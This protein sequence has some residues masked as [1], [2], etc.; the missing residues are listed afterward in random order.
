VKS[1]K[2]NNREIQFKDVVDVSL[3]EN[4]DSD[5]EINTL[6]VIQEWFSGKDRFTFQTSGSTGQPKSIEFSRD[7]IVASAKRTNS[8]F[9]LQAGQTILCCLNT[10]F[11][12]GF[13]MLIRAFVGKLKLLVVEPTSN[14]LSLV[15]EE[16]IDFVAMT[17][18]QVLGAMEQIP[19]KLGH[20]KTL[21]VGGADVQPELEERLT[22]LKCQ[23][24]HSYAMTETLTHV[25][26][27]NMSQN[28]KI[29][30]ALEGVAF[31]QAE[32]TCLVVHDKVLKI[33]ELKT[34]DL[35]DLINDQKFQWLG[36]LDN[37]VNSGGIKIQI[38]KLELTIRDLLLTLGCASKICLV[39]IHDARLTNKLVLLI[40]GEGIDFDH[41]GMLKKLKSELPAFHD[42]KEIRMVPDLFH[43]NTGKIDRIKNVNV[44][45]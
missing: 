44:Y 19:E 3:I 30:S 22:K 43:T 11:V 20:V 37:V 32:D 25:A 35:V 39:S 15:D 23:V 29:Y 26:I 38:E 45:L 42:P 14:P 5:F 6:K 18:I 36:R 21:L 13:M 31:S 28:E 7:Q 34:N 40:E 1:F 4:Q 24:F 27:R 33:H 41:V 16:T 8:V 17:P 9:Q 12:A 10:G 2:L